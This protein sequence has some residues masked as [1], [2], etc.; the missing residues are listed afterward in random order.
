MSQLERLIQQ[1]CPDGVEY[2]SLGELFD[3]KNGYTPS[4][5]HPSYWANGT[6]PWFR[7]DDIRQNGRILSAATQYVSEKAVKGTPF[8]AKSIIDATSATIGEHA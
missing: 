6:V 1:L 7:M 2:I 8:P 5:S 3:T 4:K